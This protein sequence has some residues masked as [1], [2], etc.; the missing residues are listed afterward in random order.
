MNLDSNI[1]QKTIQSLLTDVTPKVL[2]SPDISNAVLLTDSVQNVREHYTLPSSSFSQK[3]HKEDK[4]ESPITTRHKTEQKINEKKH[5]DDNSNDDDD[6]DPVIELYEQMNTANI[7]FITQTK[8]GCLKFQESDIDVQSQVPYPESISEKYLS[9]EMREYIKNSSKKILSFECKINE[10]KIF[11]QFVLFKNHN[12]EAASYY[13]TYAHRVFM[14]LHMASLKSS[15]VE[16]LNIYIYLTPFKKELP[17]N[18]SEVIGPIHANTGYTYRCEKKN[19]IVIYRQE[20]WFKVFIHETMHTFGNDF[21]AE[22]R[23]VDDMVIKK[24]FSLPQGVDIRLSETY[25]EIWARIMN[26]AFQ[27]YFKN[28]PSLESRTVKAY[29]LSTSAYRF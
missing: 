10:R 1:V 8:S 27:T 28:P 23:D 6:D 4:G 7:E 21:E 13:K 12:C 18:K 11:L 22:L 9:R 26:V 16:S 17:E 29:F 19:E 3:K 25:S 24:I 20:E 14:W 2:T 5:H 15:C